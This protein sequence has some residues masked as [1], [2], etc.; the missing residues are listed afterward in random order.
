MIKKLAQKLVERVKKRSPDFVI[1]DGDVP[2]LRRWWLIPRNRFF[3]IYIHEF[4]RS[5]DDRALHDHPWPWMSYLVEGNYTE[6]TIKEGGVHQRTE[7]EEGSLRCHLPKFAHRIEID[8]PVW[9]I[10]VTGPKIRAWGFHC[11]N[12]W[13]HWKD[14][15]DPS[16]KGKVG[17]GCGD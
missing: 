5:D 9:T 7:Y 10:F 4:L 8:K 16:D 6:H 2:Y 11:P 14:F 13:K 1:G 15:T 12:G 3:N 17:P